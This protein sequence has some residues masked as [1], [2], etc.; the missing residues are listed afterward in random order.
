[1]ARVVHR[2]AK[3]GRAVAIRELP[4]RRALGAETSEQPV[5]A[6]RSVR[7]ADEIRPA[8][9]AVVGCLKV[10]SRKVEDLRTG[11]L[12]LYD[13]R[14]SDFRLNDRRRTSCARV[15]CRWRGR[16]PRRSAR[17]PPTRR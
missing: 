12:R 8:G 11:G 7:V 10:E 16:A 6:Q 5:L 14:L 13:F 17:T 15:A 1:G 4:G 3:A 2:A 9:A